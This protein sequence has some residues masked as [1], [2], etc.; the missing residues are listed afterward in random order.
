MGWRILYHLDR[1]NAVVSWFLAA[2]V[3]TLV[4]GTSARMIPSV[5]SIEDKKT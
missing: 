2:G 4:L 5:V 3:L 1:T